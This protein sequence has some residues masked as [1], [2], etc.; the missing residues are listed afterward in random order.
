MDAEMEGTNWCSASQHNLMVV[1]FFPNSVTRLKVFYFFGK[2]ISLLDYFS[3]MTH[4]QV[5]GEW[6]D[7]I[8]I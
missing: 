2:M 1:I 4:L 5:R 7:Q 3:L 6:S 8:A